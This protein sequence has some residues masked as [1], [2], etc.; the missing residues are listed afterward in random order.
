VV[1]EQQLHHPALGLVRDVGGELG[2]DDH[3]VGAGDGAGRHRLALALDLDDALAAGARGVEEG[4]VAEAR[5][6]DADQF[7]GTDHQGAL[8]HGDLDAVD[9]DGHQV[10]GRHRRLT[11]GGVGRDGHAF[12]SR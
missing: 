4:V 3:P 5:D 6:L 9:A 11:G 8:R 10:L 12:T 2:P 1:D 7:G